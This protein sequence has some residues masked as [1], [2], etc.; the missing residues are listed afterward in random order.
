MALFQY[1]CQKWK[2]IFKTGE[3]MAWWS[4]K[5][6]FRKFAF[7]S[8]H[9]RLNEWI[10]Y[11]SFEKNDTISIRM[12]SVDV[13]QNSIFVCFR[14]FITSHFK[15]EKR[16]KVWNTTCFLMVTNAP[17]IRYMANGFMFCHALRTISNSKFVISK[18]YKTSAKI[19]ELS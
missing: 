11:T 10:F 17:L 13:K 12:S 4:A 8:F 1:V 14:V 7:L 6:Y 5:K 15:Q 16:V 2:Q 3:G 9:N 19:T 18:H